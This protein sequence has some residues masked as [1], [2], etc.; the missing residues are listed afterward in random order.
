M[1]AWDDYH[2][3]VAAWFRLRMA[4]T[5]D[6]CHRMWKRLWP[7]TQLYRAPSILWGVLHV[8]FINGYV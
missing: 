4:N 6:L 1:D 2:W 3:E 7:Q 5:M 8:C